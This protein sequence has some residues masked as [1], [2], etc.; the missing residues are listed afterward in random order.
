MGYKKTRKKKPRKGYDTPLVYLLGYENPLKDFW[1]SLIRKEGKYPFYVGGVLP[2]KEG[3]FRKDTSCPFRS[4]WDTKRYVSLKRRPF[5]SR[6][7]WLSLIRIF[8]KGTRRIFSKGFFPYFARDTCR[9]P[10]EKIRI[11]DN[12]KIRDTI[13]YF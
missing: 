10:F 2:F 5:V 3:I 13:L 11:R 9:V 4:F 1:L 8:S 6:I 7:F 12:Q